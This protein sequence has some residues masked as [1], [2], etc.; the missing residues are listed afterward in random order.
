MTIEELGSIGELL[1]AVATLVTLI[2]LAV[3]VR[4]NT[5]ALQSSTFQNITG[6]MAKNVEPI[7]TN[8]DVAAIMVKGIPDPAS[9][10][11]EERLRLAS[12][13]VATFRRLESVFV[14]NQLGSI[15]DEMKEG[16]EFSIVNLLN[17]PF[18]R[19]W[20]QS[21]RVTF[22]QPY[23]EHLEQRASAAGLTT[24]HPSMLYG[25]KDSA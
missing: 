16:F 11:P 8:E 23:V 12:V 21:A 2:Y 18:G 25:E 9:L 24:S 4:Q 5:R 20:W 22:F 1:A 3:Q 17:T 15:S 19:E 13:F 14:Q 6:E 7:S 10:T